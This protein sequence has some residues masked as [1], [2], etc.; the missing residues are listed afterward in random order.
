MKRILLYSSLIF[1]ALASGCVPTTVS[2]VVAAGPE[3]T[4][5]GQFMYFHLHSKTGVVDT[6]KANI[7]LQMEQSTGFKV[8]GDTATIH[9][10]SF[11]SYIVN[12]AYNNVDFLDNTYPTTGTPTKFHLNGVYAYTYDGTILK[13]VA[14]SAFDTLTYF[15]TLKKTGN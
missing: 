7:Q 12:T 11:G 5:T 6:T 14:Y 3:G 15:Y 2:P 13:M 1:V 10:G 4:F 8:T 9:A